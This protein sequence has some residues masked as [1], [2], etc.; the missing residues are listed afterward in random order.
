MSINKDGNV[1]IPQEIY[2]TTKAVVSKTKINAT[3]L[4]VSAQSVLFKQKFNW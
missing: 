3:K 2:D 4:N 1:E